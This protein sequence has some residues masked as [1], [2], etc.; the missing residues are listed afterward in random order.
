M[1]NIIL[2]YL[3]KVSKQLELRESFFL[4]LMRHLR[5]SMTKGITKAAAAAAAAAAVAAA[6]VTAAR[7]SASPS[8]SHQLR[9]KG[10][11]KRNSKSFFA[12]I[13]LLYHSQNH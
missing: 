13:P 1:S 8:P 6:M 4:H 11:P 12:G 10:G 9:L 5:N 7:A 3:L 2:M